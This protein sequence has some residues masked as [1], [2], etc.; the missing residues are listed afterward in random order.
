MRGVR[1]TRV[2]RRLGNRNPFLQFFEPVEN[3]P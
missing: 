1:I 2:R 3:D